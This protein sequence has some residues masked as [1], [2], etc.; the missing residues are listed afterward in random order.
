MPYIQ[1]VIMIACS[2]ICRR[3][4]SVRSIK[5]HGRKSVCGYVNYT[6][7][8]LALQINLRNDILITNKIEDLNNENYM[9]IF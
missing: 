1:S 2:I 3:K 7:E 9:L 4:E 8:H 5:S 6:T